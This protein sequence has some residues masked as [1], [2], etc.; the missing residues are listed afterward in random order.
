MD[1]FWGFQGELAGLSAAF[2][3][4]LATWVFRRVGRVVSALEMNLLKG[5]IALALIFLT[6]VLRGGDL[7]FGS[8]T[9]PF[10]LILSGIVGIGIGDTLYF[11]SLK[12][13]GARRTLLL[14]ILAPPITG[15]LAFFFL[16]EGLPPLAWL[17]ILLTMGGVAWVVGESENTAGAAASNKGR[18]VFFGLSASFC[19]A[20]GVVMAHAALTTS[21]IELMRSVFLRLAS[22]VVFLMAGMALFRRPV[23]RWRGHVHAA[24]T[25][26][27]LLLATFLGTYLAIIFQ[28]V[29]LRYADAGV[30]QTLLTTS[31]LF[32][33][34]IAFL[35]GEKPSL[36]AV[37]GALVATAGVAI[38]FL[39]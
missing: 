37:L 34:P 16:G 30:A 8:G 39:I 35:R 27:S 19:Q 12:D 23:G 18:G 9:A 25:W 36:R 17:G 21:D 5:L 22:G 31:H 24:R 14:Q 15:F 33:L 3:W 2:M 7:S 11:R 38:F 32:I 4:A 20:V 29:S 1:N 13:L 6:I 26:R 28:Q 10:W